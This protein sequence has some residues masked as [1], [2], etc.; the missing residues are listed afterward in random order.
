MR[1]IMKLPFLQLF[2]R[3]KSNK[4]AM[5]A[6][7]IG[8]G[9]SAAAFA[10]TRGKRTMPSLP[11]QNMMSNLTPRSNIGAMDTGAL[12]EFSEELLESALRDNDK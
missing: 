10:V 12:T 7:I 6:S 1:N 4:G 5:W 11:I 9:L 2:T 3:K 8:L